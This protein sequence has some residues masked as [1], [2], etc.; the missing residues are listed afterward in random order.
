MRKYTQKAT[1][2]AN[3]TGTYNLN[4]RIKTRESFSETLKNVTRKMNK[5]KKTKNDIAGPMLL[6][7]KYK[8]STRE[9]FLKC[10]GGMNTSPFTDYTNLGKLDEDKLF[11]NG[12]TVK[13]AVG[14]SGV[15]Y[16][17]YFQLVISSFKN[18]TTLSSIEV[19]GGDEKNK[20]DLLLNSVAEEINIFSEKCEL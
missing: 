3:L 2:I 12:A 9:K 5:Q 18:V 14:Y 11:F 16:T 17:P 7:S 8:K 4:I 10:Y 1:G 6:V 13:S 20:I 15:N 19:C